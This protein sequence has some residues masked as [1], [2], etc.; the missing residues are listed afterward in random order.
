V[1]DDSAKTV[2]LLMLSIRLM[3]KTRD[4][5]LAQPELSRGPDA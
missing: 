1:L 5:R 4:Q 3:T 2:L